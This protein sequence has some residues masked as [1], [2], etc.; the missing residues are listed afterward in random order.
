MGLARSMTAWRG[1]NEIEERMPMVHQAIFIAALA[2]AI[3][4]SHAAAG[5]DIG[6]VSVAG[7]ECRPAAAAATPVGPTTPSAAAPSATPPLSGVDEI[8]ERDLPPG[9]D[10]SADTVAALLALE[11][12]YAACL[13]VG[14]HAALFPLLDAS[15]HD[16]AAAVFADSEDRHASPV[17]PGEEEDIDTIAL[18][19]VRTY[20]GGYAAAVLDWETGGWIESN[21]R[22]Y[23]DTGMG[24]VVAGEVTAYGQQGEGCEAG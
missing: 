3:A 12:R 13:N 23:R 21:V 22:I 24:W 7:A 9:D 10:A 17:A 2:T 11:R 1:A 5:A 6:P 4:A 20:P 15:L 16:E 8:E 14:D 19:C 18:R